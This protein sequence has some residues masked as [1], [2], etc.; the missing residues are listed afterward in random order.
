MEGIARLR[1]ASSPTQVLTD[2]DATIMGNVV[3]P[4]DASANITDAVDVDGDVTL[5]GDL[6]AGDSGSIS[7][8]GDVTVAGG[9]VLELTQL[10]RDPLVIVS[11]ETVSGQFSTVSADG[12]SFLRECEMLSAQQTSTQT[13]LSVA[14]SVDNS[15]CGLRA[16]AIVGIALGCLLVAGVAVALILWWRSRDVKK[17]TRG[18]TSTSRR[19]TCSR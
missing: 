18:T 14:V 16:G 10:P 11:G 12:S 15:G 8:T 5:D 17:W 6:I 1:L 4:L 13:A 9:L 2:V 7:S 3:L 19:T